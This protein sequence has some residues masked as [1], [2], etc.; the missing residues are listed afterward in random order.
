MKNNDPQVSII[1]PVYN[2]AAY[3]NR[4]IDS[5]LQNDFKDIEILLLNDGSTDNSPEISNSYASAY[6]DIVR[7]IAHPNMGVARTRN[8][9]ISL[10]QGRYI[11]FLDQDDYYDPDY[12]RTF[13]EAIEASGDD[14][15][16]G[17]YKRP[18]A[19]GK[20]VKRKL[21]SGKGYYQYITTF[22]WGKIHRTSFLQ[23]NNIEFFDNNIGEDVV[24]CISE[25]GLT[26]KFKFIKY[27]GYNWFVNEE[28]VSNSK[29][30]G[31]R[32]DVNIVPWMEKMSGFPF[33]TEQ[34]K[35]YFL[36]KIP[37]YYLLHSGRDSNKEKYLET[38]EK[39]FGWLRERFPYFEK[40]HYLLCGL[41]GET[42]SVKIPIIIFMLIHKLK[43]MKLFAGV[44][45][46]G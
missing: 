33:E 46:K 8:K 20:I 36:V 45:C 16:I 41:T 18:N 43:L 11:L 17:G 23:E 29:H 4:C 28:S 3:L 34:L 42:L 31:L 32:D 9:G 1:I 27:V 2:G 30:K 35:E 10:A 5:V 26:K 37:I 38:Y 6:P 13:Y 40:N 22:A 44:Y 15:V 21:L 25:A 24:F 39:L 7:V 12:I 14:V 19:S